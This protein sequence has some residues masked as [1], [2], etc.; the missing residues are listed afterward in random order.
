[1]RVPG[2]NGFT[3]DGEP[4]NDNVDVDVY[5]ANGSKISNSIRFCGGCGRSGFTP[6]IA[7]DGDLL[8]HRVSGC[9]VGAC[10]V[11]VLITTFLLL[12]GCGGDRS[13]DSICA[14]GLTLCIP[15]VRKL[16]RVAGTGGRFHMHSDYKQDWD[17]EPMSACCMF[18]SP[19]MFGSPDW[20]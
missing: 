17:F 4:N 3:N 19:G 2:T 10:V 18:G 6:E 11:P 7:R 9:Y 16:K 15:W 12:P 14:V 5:S 20:W 1:M 13:E 8:A